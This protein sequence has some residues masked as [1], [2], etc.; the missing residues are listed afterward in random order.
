MCSYSVIVPIYKVEAVLPRCIESILNQT[1][2]DFELIL[3]DDGSPDRSGRICDEY[4]EKD[5]RIRVIH[6]QNGGVSKARNAGLDIAKGRFIVFID[7]DDYVDPDYLEQH[8]KNVAD[9][10][11]SGFRCEGYHITNDSFKPPKAEYYADLS[12]EQYV[13]LFERCQFNLSCLKL[14]SASIIDKY[15][16]RFNESI[17]RSEDLLFTVQ[18]AQHCKTIRIISYIG[19]CYVIYEHETLSTIKLTA[20][21]LHKLEIANDLV[22]N[23][24]AD[25]LQDKAKHAVAKRAGIAYRRVLSE[26]IQSGESGIGFVFCLFSKRWFRRSLDHVDEIYADE[27]PKYRALLKTKSPTL[28]CLYRMYVKLRNR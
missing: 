25:Y 8:S 10:V 19:Y 18:Y 3:A 24:L 20:E 22:Y 14:F 2:S 28:F 17:S 27:D 15:R 5:K 4:A 26:C 6:Q 7:S 9:L 1:V 13:E 16:I 12:K 21:G 23:A 11:I